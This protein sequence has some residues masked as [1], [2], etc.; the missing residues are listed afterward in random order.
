[1][2]FLCFHMQYYRQLRATECFISM[3]LLP[4]NKSVQ[5]QL[6]QSATD[7]QINLK[8]RHYD[9]TDYVNDNPDTNES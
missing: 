4:S 2:T 7:H 8:L 1:M 9:H 3:Y 5:K 6:T